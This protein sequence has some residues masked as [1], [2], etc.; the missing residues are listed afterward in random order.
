MRSTVHVIPENKT[1]LRKC[2]DLPLAIIITPMAGLTT[3]CGC[4]GG[5]GGG[6][7]AVNVSSS[8]DATTM[9]EGMD[10]IILH[11]KDGN[12]ENSNDDTAADPERIPVIRKSDWNS[13]NNNDTLPSLQRGAAVTPP[14]CDRCAAYFNP[15]CTST[16]K[17]SSFFQDGATYYNCPMCGTCSSIKV[18]EEDIMDGIFD[19]VTRC[20][21][22]EYEVDGPYCVRK[23]GPVQNV[24]LYGVE[25][26]SPSQQSSSGNAT[27]TTFAAKAKQSHWAAMFST[28]SYVGG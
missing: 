3:L 17:S 6:D 7:N 5:G 23:E 8:S 24:H 27:S 10:Y 25:Y 15:Y 26:L 9:T 28:C 11:S 21:T 18:R 20:G 2:G 22:V 12:D 1:I 13:N 16:V 14:R 19:A 4:G